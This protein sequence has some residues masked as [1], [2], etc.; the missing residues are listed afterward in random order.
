[1]NKK[2]LHFLDILAKLFNVLEIVEKDITDE[3]TLKLISYLKKELNDII[4]ILLK[5][6]KGEGSLI[7]LG[8][9]FNELIEKIKKLFNL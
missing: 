5:L 4:G 2:L 7:V 3:E 8:L 6:Q 1:M 9:L